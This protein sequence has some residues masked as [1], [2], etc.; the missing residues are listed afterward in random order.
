MKKLLVVA[1]LGLVACGA[2][3]PP[4]VNSTQQAGCFG[5]YVDGVFVETICGEGGPSGPRG[6]GGGRTQCYEC[7]Y[8]PAAGDGY[9]GTCAVV[10]EGSPVCGY[11][12]PPGCNKPGVTCMKFCSATGPRCSKGRS[13]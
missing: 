3:E 6:G 9:A 8:S 11:T 4:D 12:S 7:Q 2:I 5:V 10:D 1:V 13:S